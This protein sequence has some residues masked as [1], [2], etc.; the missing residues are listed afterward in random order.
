MPG[1]S[2]F[3]PRR[4]ARHAAALTLVFAGVLATGAAAGSWS[5]DAQEGRERSRTRTFAHP[6]GAPGGAA[7]DQAPAL[8]VDRR[9]VE[10]AA[11]QAAQDGKSGSEAATEVVTRSGDR[12]SAVYSAR[13]YEG[14]ARSLDGGYVGVGLSARRSAEGRTEVDSVRPG[15]P[16]ARAGIRPGDRIRSVDGQEVDGFPVTEVVARL[17]GD[18]AA[19]GRWGGSGEGD[20]GNG[21]PSAVGVPGTPVTVGLRRGDRVWD[22]TLYRARL[23]T[24]SVAVERLQ[25]EGTGARATRIKVESFTRGTGERVGRAVRAAGPAEGILLDLRGNSGGLVTEAVTAASAF[26]DGGLVATYDVRGSQ[27]ALEAR[28]GGATRPPLVV[29]VDGGTMSAAEL[30]TGALQDRGRAVVVGS[31]TFGKGSVQMPT[32]LADGSVAELTVG[33]YRT[34]GGRTVDGRGIAP[35]LVVRGDAERR[36][37]TVLSGLGGGS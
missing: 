25:D 5:A 22:R 17:R 33:H 3:V 9:A 1:P 23:V 15:S 36:A 14:F 6:A 31:P 28:P 12:W 26:L 24:E 10:A 7:E 13:E 18:A 16:A 35:D 27:R 20:G 37:R 4:R 8:P 30:L 2:M 29:L 11:A 21:P 34:P 19:P 32:R